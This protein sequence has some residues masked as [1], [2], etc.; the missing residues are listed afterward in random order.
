MGEEIRNFYPNEAV[1]LAKVMKQTLANLES[2][3]H[4]N[5]IPEGMDTGEDIRD[6]DL[7]S[8]LSEIY[9]SADAVVSMFKSL[10]ISD[11]LILDLCYLFHYLPT[12]DRNILA[13][14]KNTYKKMH[15]ARKFNEARAE[16][17]LG[18]S[19]INDL[20]MTARAERAVPSYKA[21]PGKEE[22][23][24]KAI[25]E[26]IRR[27]AGNPPKSLWGA[28]SLDRH[29]PYVHSADYSHLDTK[30]VTRIDANVDAYFSTDRGKKANAIASNELLN[31]LK[32]GDI[33]HNGMSMREFKLKFAA[34]EAIFDN[35]ADITT[36]AEN[37]KN[38]D[39]A[40]ETLSL[41]EPMHK[42]MSELDASCSGISRVHKGIAMGASRFTMDAAYRRFLICSAD[43]QSV[44]FESM[45]IT[46]WSPA[47]VREFFL[48]HHNMILAYMQADHGITFTDVWA[49]L[50]FVCRRDG[51][52]IDMAMENGMVQGW[53][54]KSDCVLHSHILYF[55]TA[56]LRQ[57]SI[58]TSTEGYKG[59]VMIDDAV[60]CFFFSDK[61][62]PAERGIKCRSVES[63]IDEVYGDL[64]LTIAKDKTII[65]THMFTFLNKLFSQGAEVT[66]PIRTMIKIFQQAQIN[67]SPPFKTRC[68]T[69]W[70]RLAARY[71]KV[72]T[73]SCVMY[74]PCAF[75]LSV[76]SH[77]IQRS[78]ILT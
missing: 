71:R 25:K 49:H 72:Q 4:S 42:I 57:N 19:Q 55:V 54:G 35:I 63:A 6:K 20:L 17:F 45:D 59:E 69:Q 53:T 7:R 38:A 27:G 40:R 75:A 73:L 10:G 65:S 22:E 67:L 37:T 11:G 46:A 14:M 44:V 77:G 48:K 61:S 12:P 1:N 43:P 47:A 26:A 68:K 56:T 31:S 2:A 3:Y 15:A 9:R 64:G 24:A 66:K 62:S 50:R 76:L 36:K 33:V 58:L 74:W 23:V 70:G 60:Y 5:A 52:S 8:S 16:E 29:F 13:L 78:L 32:N 21:Q 51:L 34:G 30:D 41:N 39:T 28:A 18:F